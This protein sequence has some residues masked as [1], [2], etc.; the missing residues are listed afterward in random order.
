MS[1]YPFA[2]AGFVFVRLVAEGKMLSIRAREQGFSLLEAL[3]AAVVVVILL[4]GFMGSVVGSFLAD[5][6]SRNTG[7]AVN[8]ARQTME[9]AVELDYAD[10]LAL[11][12]DT[13]LTGEGMAVRIS[14]VQSTPTLALIE[15]WVCRP[16]P[17]LTL[18]QLQ[19]LSLDG[20]KQLRSAPGS[21]FS[22]VTMKHSP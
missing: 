12:G 16:A 3:I 8:V 21:Q 5:A 4:L 13:S 22:L 19:A 2:G 7:L 10:A 9:E 14:V 20:I 17:A 11:D 15:V 18:V 1:P 6:G